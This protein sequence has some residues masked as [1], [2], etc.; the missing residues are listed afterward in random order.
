MRYDDWA[1]AMFFSSRME[2]RTWANRVVGDARSIHAP[3]PAA[4]QKD[5]LEL[6]KCFRECADELDAAANKGGDTTDHISAM[7]AGG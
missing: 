2:A 1:R 7:A 6:A 3:L 5:M 4:E